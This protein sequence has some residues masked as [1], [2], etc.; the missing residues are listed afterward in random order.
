MA[1]THALEIELAHT[2]VQNDPASV[3]P[4]IKLLCCFRDSRNSPDAEEMMDEVIGSLYA[5]TDHFHK[6]LKEFVSLAA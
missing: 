6:S 5:K 4:L 3:A 2:A 1:S